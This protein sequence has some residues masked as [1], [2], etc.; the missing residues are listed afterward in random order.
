MSE[1][2][3]VKRDYFNEL[4]AIS[5]VKTNPDLVAFIEKELDLLARKN[6]QSRKP[7]KDQEENEKLKNAIVELADN[8]ITVSEYAV[9]LE[10]KFPGN[11]YSPQKVSALMRSLIEENRIVKHTDKKKSLF[12]RE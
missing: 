2:K 8:P 10:K 1:K 7:T 5:E 11:R 6:S 9:L 12:A 4:L 3:K